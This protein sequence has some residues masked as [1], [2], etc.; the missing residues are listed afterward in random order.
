MRDGAPRA[1]GARERHQQGM[2]PCSRA[3][4]GA[5]PIN[6]APAVGAKWVDPTSPRVRIGRPEV[7]VRVRTNGAN[8]LETNESRG[9]APRSVTPVRRELAAV[10]GPGPSAWTCDLEVQ[11]GNMLIC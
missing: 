8:V 2:R 5:A 6:C 4:A 11:R 10:G 3:R 7:C 9:E 1:K